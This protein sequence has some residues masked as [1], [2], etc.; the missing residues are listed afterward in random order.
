MRVVPLGEFIIGQAL[1][2]KQMLV[3]YLLHCEFIQVT[4]QI[5][6]QSNV[7]FISKYLRILMISN[8]INAGPKTDKVSYFVKGEMGG[9]PS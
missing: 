9:K 4:F 2:C 3:Y 6:H 7:T 1:P 8:F 5:W